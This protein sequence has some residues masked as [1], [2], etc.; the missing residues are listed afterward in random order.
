MDIAK[1]F[2][3]SSKKRDLS[4]KS[5]DGEDPKKQREGSLN[6][7]LN[8]SS[9]VFAEGLKSPECVTILF[10]CLQN[11]E[12]QVKEIHEISKDTK[13]SQIKGEKQ[14]KDLS[15]AI[16]FINE[17]FEEYEK[18]RREKEKEIKDLKNNVVFL[19]SKIEELDKKIDRQE[20]YSRR[21]CILLHGI[22]EEKDE[23]N[24]DEIVMKVLKEEMGEELTEQ[25]IGRSHRIGKIK[26]INNKPRPII[27]KF[28]RYNTRNKIF[29]NKK[30]LKGKGI[31]ITESL[32]V[33]RME[34]LKNAREEHEYKNVW[35]QDGKILYVDSSDG[36]IK[37]FYD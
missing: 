12:K 21:N 13:D 26:K 15:E 18:D 23:K 3:R 2:E 28:S 22:K 32:T 11:L 19:T 30:K 6:D 5:N 1:F 37:L 4:D 17:K 31:S 10:N 29:M 7:S 25:D 33:K 9:D 16:N 27:V 36:K 14:L 24:T 35:T 20:Q 8:D 34:M